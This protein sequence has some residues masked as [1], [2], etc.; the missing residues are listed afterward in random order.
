MNKILLLFS[1]VFFSINFSQAQC[2][3][4]FFSEYVEGY[5]NN[6]ALEIYNPTATAINLA[7]YSIARFSNGSTVAGNNKIIQLPSEMIAPFDVFVLVVDLTDT[8]DWDTQFDK[9]A[10]NGY[11]LSLIHI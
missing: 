10:W 6:K 8:D 7:D 5:A 4:L 11:N 2:S 1:F 3:E 9:P